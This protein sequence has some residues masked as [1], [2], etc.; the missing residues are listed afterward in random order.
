MVSL[1]LDAKRIGDSQVIP[2]D[3]NASILGEMRP[4]LPII[5]VKGVFNRHNAVLLD[6]M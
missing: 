3:L 4:S 2:N 1:R 5:L 6:P